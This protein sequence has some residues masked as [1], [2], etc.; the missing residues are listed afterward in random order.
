M[1]GA[2]KVSAT[3]SVAIIVTLVPALNNVNK[4]CADSE[5]AGAHADRFGG[6]FARAE[7]FRSAVLIPATIF[8]LRIAPTVEA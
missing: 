5:K 1:G 3:G 6:T 4:K 7:K 2:R 8:E